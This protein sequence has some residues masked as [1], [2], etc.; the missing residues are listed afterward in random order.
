[1]RLRF[2]TLKKLS[3]YRVGH[4]KSWTLVPV[5]MAL[6]LLISRIVSER[7][8]GKYA[9]NGAIRAREENLSSWLLEMGF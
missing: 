6:A 9:G 4:R 1:M 7:W 2:T 5:S 8:L 3:G